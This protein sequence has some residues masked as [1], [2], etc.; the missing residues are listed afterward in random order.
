LST[1]SQNPEPFPLRGGHDNPCAY[2]AGIGPN[3]TCPEATPTPLTPE[4]LAEYAALEQAATEGPWNPYR[5]QDGSVVVFG[6]GRTWFRLSDGAPEER[7]ATLFEAQDGTAADAA[8]IASAR[9]AVPEL[10][11]EVE[12]LNRLVKSMLAA[13]TE[14]DCPDPNMG[15]LQIVVS[16]MITL[17]EAEAERDKLAHELDGA[18]L[19]L[20][21]EEQTT[22]RLRLAY[23]SARERAAAYGE[24]I[25]RVVGDRESYQGWL[26]DAEA[27]RDQLKKRVA[28]LEA[29]PSRADV[30]N[31]AADE[32]VAFC[33]DHGDRDTSYMSCHCPAA[34]DLRR[35]AKGGTR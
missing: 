25:L 20:W 9:T 29:A 16:T 2:A 26:K 10:L 33:P 35:T 17:S 30:L 22:A 19:S 8:F 12:R 31:E 21:E 32:L 5:L 27:E 1:S 24:G 3:C 23:R 6:V 11:A 18:S 13:V 15:P 34:D 28:E 7:P 4:R 14:Y